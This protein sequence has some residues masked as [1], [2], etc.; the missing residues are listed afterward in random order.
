MDVAVWNRGHRA[1]AGFAIGALVAVGAS[2]VNSAAAQD[3][4]PVGTGP[5]PAFTTTTSTVSPATTA[6]APVTTAPPSTVP[7]ATSAPPTTTSP[8]AATPSAAEPELKIDPFVVVDKGALALVSGSGVKTP[9]FADLISGIETFSLCSNGA[10][11][12]PRPADGSVLLAGPTG[13]VEISGLGAPDR[14]LCGDRFLVVG[15]DVETAILE[16]DLVGQLIATLRH[17]FPSG[18]ALAWTEYDVVARQSATNGDVSH[19][20]MLTGGVSPAPEDPVDPPVAPGAMGT[21][22]SVAD[23]LLSVAGSDGAV[24]HVFEDCDQATFAQ[25]LSETQFNDLFG[26]VLGLPTVIGAELATSSTTVPAVEEDAPDESVDGDASPTTT[27]TATTNPEALPKSTDAGGFGL[28]SVIGA[29]IAAALAALAFLWWWRRRPSGGSKGGGTWK[30]PAGGAAP[31]D[32]DDSTITIT[33]GDGNAIIVMEAPSG[34]GGPTDDGADM[35]DPYGGGTGG[36]TGADEPPPRD[37][38][39]ED[40][41]GNDE[42]YPNSGGNT[43]SDEPHGLEDD[44]GAES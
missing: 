31:N 2:G 38:G 23:G 36:N 13:L 41:S 30:N 43:G 33:D 4:G 20:D 28:G 19:I 18:S 39:T 22:P 34:Y 7:P 27:R 25:V 40:N 35:P 42:P 11:A 17:R 12:I 26:L 37:G 21:T 3:G 29:F 5:P 32:S 6:P 1:L 8:A 15:D 16:L 10:L 14:V 44:P 9:L 24:I